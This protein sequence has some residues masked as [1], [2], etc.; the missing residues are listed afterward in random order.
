MEAAD[1]C[2]KVPLALLE[3]SG[4][5]GVLHLIDAVDI[6]L[7]TSESE[8]L[9]LQPSS[10]AVV[11]VSRD[12][13]TVATIRQVEVGPRYAA[14]GTHQNPKTLLRS[15][16]YAPVLRRRGCRHDV[17]EGRPAGLR[18]PRVE[19]RH[20]DHAVLGVGEEE[21]Q[22]VRADGVGR[23][24]RVAAV[25]PEVRRG[26]VQGAHRGQRLD[27]VLQLQPGLLEALQPAG[28]GRVGSDGA[29]NMARHRV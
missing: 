4:K 24:L 9:V 2:L 23:L 27:A 15:G 16:G 6:V 10:R 3:V 28:G 8:G 18:R 1:R 19:G 29:R 7:Q 14:V 26:L 20:V 11:E 22:L 17:G 5:V 25:A 12:G 21:G 13:P